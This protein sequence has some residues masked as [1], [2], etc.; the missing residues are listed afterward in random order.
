MRG[1]SEEATI[2]AHAGPKGALKRNASGVSYYPKL[3]QLTASS[4]HPVQLPDLELSIQWPASKYT[5]KI[6]IIAETYRPGLKLLDYIYGSMH[7]SFIR[8]Q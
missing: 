2:N 5:I 7:S 6:K 3:P 4:N 1:H 8:Q